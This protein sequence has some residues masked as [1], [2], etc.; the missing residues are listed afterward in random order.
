MLKKLLMFSACF[1]LVSGVGVA[2]RSSNPGDKLPEYVPVPNWL[3]LPK[4]FKF[5]LVTAVATDKDDNL[6][7]FHRGKQPIAV[8]DK[9]GK[10]LRSWGDGQVKTAHG[11][12]IDHEGNVWTTDLSTHQVIKYDP[13]GKVLLTLGKRKKPGNTPDQFNMPAD[14]AISPA[15]DIYVADGYGNSRVVKFSKD[16]KYLKE[17]GKKGKQ[18]GEFDLVHAIFL[19]SKGRVYVGDRENDRIQVFDAEGK[20][21]EQWRDCGAPYGLFLQGGQRMLVADGRGNQVR[22]LD[23]NGK[24]LAR[25]GQKGSG[26]GQFLMPHGITADAQGVIY[27]AEGD[28]ER[29]Q[30]FVAR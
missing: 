19:D 26:A 17:W 27:V 9:A 2:A 10:F 18:T 25:F 3:Q 11:L 30:K 7:I 16:G 29:P 24:I 14:V 20:F 1:A 13:A 21:L 5:G 28:G 22:I 12:R 6:F 15:G 8:F 23:L 4:G